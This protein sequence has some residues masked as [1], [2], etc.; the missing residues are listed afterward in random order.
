VRLIFFWRASRTMTQG[1]EV[2]TPNVD[3]NSSPEASGLAPME[4]VT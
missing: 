1:L 4:V 3:I 2:A